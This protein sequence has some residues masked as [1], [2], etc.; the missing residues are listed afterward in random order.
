MVNAP[1]RDDAHLADQA[2]VGLRR[3]CTARA[4]APAEPVNLLLIGLEHGKGEELTEAGGSNVTRRRLEDAD[5]SCPSASRIFSR[6]SACRKGFWTK[7]RT[8]SSVIP[9]TL[10][11][12]VYP[13]E[14]STRT[15]GSI[16]F[17]W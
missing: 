3:I 5:H 14:R 10:V 17:I 13:E 9:W 4:D 8:P 6:S 1:C 7:P 11:S 15:R 16:F 2:A 12:T